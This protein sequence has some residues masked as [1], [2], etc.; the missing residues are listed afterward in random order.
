ME[1]LIYITGKIPRCF[2][3]SDSNVEMKIQDSEVSNQANVSSVE[4]RQ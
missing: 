3:V 4:I 2:K 1:T